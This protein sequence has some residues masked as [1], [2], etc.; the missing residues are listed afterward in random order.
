MN[1]SFGSTPHL[2]VAARATNHACIYFLTAKVRDSSVRILD[3]C[4]FQPAAIFLIYLILSACLVTRK[5]R[6]FPNVVVLVIYLA[7]FAASVINC[8]RPIVNVLLH[9]YGTSSEVPDKILWALLRFTL[10][11]AELSLFAVG[12]ANSRRYKRLSEKSIVALSI[13]VSL[14]HGVI[15]GC[16][17]L[18]S[19]SPSDIEFTLGFGGIKLAICTSAVCFLI[20]LSLLVM[21][22]MRRNLFFHLPAYFHLTKT[23][24]YVYCIFLLAVY[25]TLLFGG[26]AFFSGQTNGLCA[27]A[28]SSF[29]YYLF[30]AP[31]VYV[32]FLRG[33]FSSRKG[34]LA[35]LYQS[36]LY[37]SRDVGLSVNSG[38]IRVP[39]YTAVACN[40]DPP[41][42]LPVSSMLMA[43]SGTALASPAKSHTLPTT[44][45]DSCVSTNL[46]KW[47]GGDSGD[48]DAEIDWASR[49]LLGDR[50]GNR[51][52]DVSPILSRAPGMCRDEDGLRRIGELLANPEG[53][54]S[55]EDDEDFY[56]GQPN[57]ARFETA[58]HH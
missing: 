17:D 33:Y 42:P 12:C 10:M 53:L 30:Y 47:D 43:R 26:I 1:G 8:V 52:E 57:P 16:V 27:I 51:D 34:H 56:T 22:T 19:D 6:I 40:S 45:F 55:V 38:D 4:F 50:R 14:V 48:D 37:R 54:L 58:E 9:S 18:T 35:F 20:Y 2:P 7:T 13:T 21:L 25:S 24:V 23:S 46:N 49:Q 3:L 15:Q 11:S 5:L 32:L 28:F 44:A 41:H 31:L 36:D 29:L 39:S